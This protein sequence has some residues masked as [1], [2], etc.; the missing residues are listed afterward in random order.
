MFGKT[1]SDESKLKMSK[2]QTGRKHTEESKRKIGLNN[3]GFNGRKHS[4]ETKKLASEYFK[5]NNPMA[6][7]CIIDGIVY[8][9]LRDASDILQI[10]IYYLKNKLKSEKFTNYCYLN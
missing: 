4:D 6:K 3:I 7:K 1:H 8:N 5:H 9:T 2:S 10:S